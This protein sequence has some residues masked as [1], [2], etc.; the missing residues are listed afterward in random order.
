[1]KILRSS[2]CGSLESNDI[3]IQITPIKNGIEVELASIVMVQFGDVIKSVIHQTLRDLD[4]EGVSVYAVDRGALDCT[5]RARVETA[6]A[7]A[8]EE[9]ML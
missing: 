5:I 7:R 4:V 6:V 8:M 1:M 3:M 9:V 2:V